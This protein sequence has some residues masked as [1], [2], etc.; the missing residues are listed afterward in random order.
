ML[1]NLIWHQIEGTQDRF[2]KVLD[3]SLINFGLFPGDIVEIKYSP[4]VEGGIEVWELDGSLQARFLELIGAGWI[5]AMTPF[6]SAGQIRF[7]LDPTRAGRIER[8]GW[9]DACR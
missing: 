5:Q 6:L 7:F 2:A 9:I 4:K 8:V 3:E 1:P